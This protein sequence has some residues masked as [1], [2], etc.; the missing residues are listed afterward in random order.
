MSVLTR[1][2]NGKTFAVIEYKNVKKK[3]KI[4]IDSNNNVD[5]SC[6]GIKSVNIKHKVNKVDLSFNPISSMQFSYKGNANKVILSKECINNLIDLIINDIFYFSP[7]NKIQS[8]DVYSII[9]NSYMLENKYKSIIRYKVD[10]IKGVI[11]EKGSSIWTNLCMKSEDEFTYKVK[12]IQLES[13][14]ISTKLSAKSVYEKIGNKGFLI[15]DVDWID[16]DYIPS[17]YLHKVNEDQLLY[18]MKVNNISINSFSFESNKSMIDV[19]K[20]IDKEISTK[21]K[22]RKSISKSLRTNVWNKYCGETYSGNCWMCKKDIKIMDSWHVSHIISHKH[23]GDLS[24]S[25]LRPCCSEC[26]LR[27][28]DI[29]MQEQMYIDENANLDIKTKM[30]YDLLYHLLNKCK[31]E[32]KKYTN[33]PDVYISPKVSLENRINLVKS[34]DF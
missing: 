1:V 12:D 30:F 33:N 11:R 26:N 16:N 29:D 31:N 22:Q 5:L 7:N 19:I 14:N 13:V 21:S 8:K 25:N 34:M 2:I 6:M 23:G 20:I 9:I 4:E 28:H 18:L 3:V 27:T 24:L 10:S 17:N 32:L 15:E